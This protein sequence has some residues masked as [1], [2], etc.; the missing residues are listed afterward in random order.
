MSKDDLIE[1]QSTEIYTEESDLAALRAF[2][3]DI[4]C[5][6]PLNAENCKN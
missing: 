2:L 3:L 6:T 4:D 1:Q 5:L